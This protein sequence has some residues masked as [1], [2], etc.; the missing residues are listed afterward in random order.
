VTAAG[1]ASGR[2]VLALAFTVLD[3]SG[4]S[5]PVS[6]TITEAAPATKGA[7]AARAGIPAGGDKV[8]GGK[9]EAFPKGSV[10][11]LQLSKPVTIRVANK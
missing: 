3:V 1:P 9:N 10:L 4:D 2:P 7:D 8:A 11:S 6:A 5:Y